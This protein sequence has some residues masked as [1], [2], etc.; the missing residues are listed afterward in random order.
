MISWRD[1]RWSERLKA[2]VGIWKCWVGS[3]LLDNRKVQSP[4]QFGGA[5]Y[6]K[7]LR[8]FTIA[9]EFKAL[10]SCWIHCCSPIQGM[11]LVAHL[12]LSNSTQV[13][14]SSPSP[15]FK[16]GSDLYK[17]NSHIAK[18][19]IARCQ[20]SEGKNSGAQTMDSECALEM[21]LLFC[22]L[23][24]G[25][26]SVFC[27]NYPLSSPRFRKTVCLFLGLFVWPFCTSMQWGRCSCRRPMSEDVR[28]RQH[29]YDIKHEIATLVF[30]WLSDQ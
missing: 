5:S 1:W 28:F 26:A 11:S 8:V 4:F 15:T 17:K 12:C 10:L 20:K 2:V 7:D 16:N 13:G 19:K 27:V 29:T 22:L 24:G 21:C 25:W 6:K 18:C 23:C 9:M 30:R 14:R 3:Q